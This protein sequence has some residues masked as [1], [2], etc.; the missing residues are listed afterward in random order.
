MTLEQAILDAV[1]TLPP[2][3]QKV[4]LDHAK[5]LREQ[6]TEPKRPR[7]NGRGLWAEFNIDLAAEDIDEARR[8][9][10]KNFPRDDF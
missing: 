3:K 10:W 7:Q 4:L 1:R 8:E 6:S 9:M 5:Q 2:D